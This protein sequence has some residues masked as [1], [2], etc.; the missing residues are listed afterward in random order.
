LEILRDVE[1]RIAAPRPMDY[2][3]HQTART[4]GFSV[5]DEV[6]KVRVWKGKI[7]RLSAI[8]EGFMFFAVVWQLAC[9]HGMFNGFCIIILGS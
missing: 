7:R 5:G 6:C 2:G 9:K 4:S 3:G 1:K 8:M